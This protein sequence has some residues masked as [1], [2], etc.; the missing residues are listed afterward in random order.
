MTRALAPLATARVALAKSAGA[1]GELPEY[2]R[3]SEVANACQ[4]EANARRRSLLRF[5]WL[6]G[7]RV[8][9]V[10]G[11]SAT[12]G[13]PGL[14]VCDL[15]LGAKTAKL[16]TLKRRK[17]VVRTLPIPGEHL[18]ELA[19]VIAAGGLVATDRLFPW[20]RTRAFELVRDML[21]AAGVE[22]SRCHPHALR[23]GHAVH[24]VLNGVPLNVVQR[25][26]GH[27]SIVTTSIYTQV[28]GSDV[29]REY[30]RIAW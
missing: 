25:A 4:I 26:L 30:D 2:V 7:A 29:R 19:I 8:S 17:V 21:L 23:H 12:G 24:A 9:E 15:D 14:R 27:A 10:V 13:A 28:T 6:T 1:G 5:L 22:R 18:G 3:A 20:S 16:R 11:Q